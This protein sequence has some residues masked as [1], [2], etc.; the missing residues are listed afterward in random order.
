MICAFCIKDFS[1]YPNLIYCTRCTSRLIDRP[2]NSD[3]LHFIAK[4]PL[5]FIN[6]VKWNYN[7]A[8]NAVM[9][10]S[11]NRVANDE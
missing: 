7:I 5:P 4:Q 8:G 3:E 6:T 2:F 11:T 9:R 1:S 10:E